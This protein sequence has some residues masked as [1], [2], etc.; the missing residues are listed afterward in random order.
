MQVRYLLLTPLLLA[1]FSLGAPLLLP[2]QSVLQRTNKRQRTKQPYIWQYD[3]SLHS[4]NICVPFN[5]ESP[6]NA[7]IDPFNV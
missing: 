6:G 2:A 5:I 3:V 1:C 4:T 7:L